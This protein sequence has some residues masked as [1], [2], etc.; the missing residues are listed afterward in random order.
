MYIE[1]K[2]P[3]GIS[4][5]LEGDL[6][7]EHKENT[8]TDLINKGYITVTPLHYDLTNFKIINEVSKWFK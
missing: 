1:K 6:I 8:D 3:E 4:Y 7:N 5:H 2:T